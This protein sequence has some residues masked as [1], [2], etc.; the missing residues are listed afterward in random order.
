MA[1]YEIPNIVYEIPDGIWS[2]SIRAIPKIGEEVDV[3]LNK[4]GKAEVVGYRVDH[5]YIALIVK[6]LNRP[7]YMRS[8]YGE[9]YGAE[10]R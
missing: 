4:L 3:I 6:F 9:V 10:I 1:T 2:N 8:P 7:N 5:G